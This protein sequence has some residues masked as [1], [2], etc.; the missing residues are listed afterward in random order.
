MEKLA[1]RGGRCCRIISYYL[2]WNTL[3]SDTWGSTFF[4]RRDFCSLLNYWLYVLFY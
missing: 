4:L 2:S 1:T 3:Q